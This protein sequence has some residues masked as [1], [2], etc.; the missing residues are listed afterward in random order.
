MFR[1][2]SMLLILILA[3]FFSLVSPFMLYAAGNITD[4][5]FTIDLAPMDPLGSGQKAGGAQ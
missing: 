4:K 5:T 2:F 1:F 3:T